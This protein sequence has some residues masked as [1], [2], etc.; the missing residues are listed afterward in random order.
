MSGSA[1]LFKKKKMLLPRREPKG[2]RSGRWETQ[3]KIR[4]PLHC[5]ILGLLT[6]IN[7]S[8]SNINM[9]ISMNKDGKVLTS[10]QPIEFIYMCRTV[11][12]VM[13][14]HPKCPYMTGCLLITDTFQCQLKNNLVDRKCNLQF[15][16]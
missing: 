11:T 8:K 9:F 12:P 1:G 7:D 14:G 15:G 4:P 10:T 16:S 6:I 2:G 3:N 13:R 5:I